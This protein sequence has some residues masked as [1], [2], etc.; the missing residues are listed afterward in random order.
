[1]I[2]PVRSGRPTRE[3]VLA[4]GNQEGHLLGRLLR[5]HILHEGQQFPPRTFDNQVE[6]TPDHQGGRFKF[7]IAD[8]DDT[9][10]RAISFERNFD[11]L[12]QRQ[13]F[14]I[15]IDGYLPGLVRLDQ[16]DIEAV[17]FS[18]RM[19]LPEIG[20]QVEEVLLECQLFYVAGVDFDDRLFVGAKF[21]FGS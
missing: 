11:M 9:D 18:D 19:G 1:M 21:S 7:F 8:I 14:L 12:F 6:I 20:F 16:V 3:D 4:V 5:A 10:S 17:Y 2:D 13:V 15:V